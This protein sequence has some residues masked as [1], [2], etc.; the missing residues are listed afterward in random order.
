MIVKS[1]VD[2][3]AINNEGMN[4]LA[5]ATQAK[6]LSTMTWML[7]NISIIGDKDSIEIAK[8]FAGNFMTKESILLNMK[9]IKT[10]S[11]DLSSYS[12]IKAASSI[13]VLNH[14]RSNNE[15]GGLRNHN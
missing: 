6:D 5:I 15:K 14:K 7:D 3:K 11:N 13:T 1:G 12:S 10:I 9:R 8:K 2:V 4:A